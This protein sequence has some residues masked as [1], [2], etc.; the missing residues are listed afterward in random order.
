[1][2]MPGT[3]EKADICKR[4]PLNGR[5]IVILRS[6]SRTEGFT[7]LKVYHFTTNPSTDKRDSRG[8]GPLLDLGSY[9][10]NNGKT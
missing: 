8:Q 3:K 7:A 9:F 6:G 2:N 1:M 5:F 10:L 4:Q